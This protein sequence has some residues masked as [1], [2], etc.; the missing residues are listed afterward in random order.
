MVFRILFPSLYSDLYKGA[1]SCC[2]FS[3]FHQNVP[4]GDLPAIR[5]LKGTDT[6]VVDHTH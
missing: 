6:V 5:H 4:L 3:G 1:A 2:A